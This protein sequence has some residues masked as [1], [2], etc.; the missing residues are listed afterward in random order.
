MNPIYPAL[1][2]SQ[3]QTQPV[4]CGLT[5]SP[6]RVDRQGAG[7]SGCLLAATGLGIIPAEVSPRKHKLPGAV[8]RSPAVPGNLIYKQPTSPAA[9]CTIGGR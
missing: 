4:P 2:V 7:R 9:S 8:P 6:R 1:F 5:F 3:Q